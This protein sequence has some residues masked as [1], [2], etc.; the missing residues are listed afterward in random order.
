MLKKT[1]ALSSSTDRATTS[2]SV[3]EIEEFIF[4][5]ADF[6]NLDFYDKKKK[7]TIHRV[8][9]YANGKYILG[10]TTPCYQS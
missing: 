7:Q 6:G 3:T 4:E 8:L 9:V 5:S 10:E 2:N 1:A